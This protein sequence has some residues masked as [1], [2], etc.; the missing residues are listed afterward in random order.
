MLWEILFR[1][2]P[3]FPHNEPLSSI[4]IISICTPR[5]LAQV[6]LEIVVPEIV[7][8]LTAALK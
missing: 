1:I 4:E 5:S 2:V 6:F 3:K 8:R 7:G